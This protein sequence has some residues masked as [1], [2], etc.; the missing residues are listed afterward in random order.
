MGFGN[1]LFV[2][3]GWAVGFLEGAS[4]LPEATVAGRSQR[5]VGLQASKSLDESSLTEISDDSLPPYSPHGS[6][7]FS[8]CG[9]STMHRFVFPS[10]SAPCTNIFRGGGR[11]HI[12]CIIFLNTNGNFKLRVFPLVYIGL[13]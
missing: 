8:H 11:S 4:W 12:L 10:Y 3:G 2:R 13:L 5:P 6:T 1:L 9:L 7:Y